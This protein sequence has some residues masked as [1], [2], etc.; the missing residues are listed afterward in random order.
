ME[1]KRFY[2]EFCNGMN[3][4][5]QSRWFDNEKETREFFKESFDL[6]DDSFDV[7]LMSAVWDEKAGCYGDITQEEK[8]K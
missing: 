6:I 3:Y 4:M 5:I 2:I 1:D 7:Y 8:L